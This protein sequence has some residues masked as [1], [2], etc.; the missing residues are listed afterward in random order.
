M[1]VQSTIMS[2]LFCDICKNTGK[3]MGLGSIEKKCES[4]KNMKYI[5]DKF[6][7]IIK[8]ICRNPFKN[9]PVKIAILIFLISFFILWISKSYESLTFSLGAFVAIFAALKY[10]LDQANY[11]KSLFEKRYKIFSIIDEV[12]WDYASNLKITEEMIEKISLNLMRRSYFLFSKES[13]LFIEKFRRALIDIKHLDSLET[14]KNKNFEE[15]VKKSSEFLV[16][17]IDKQN[18]SDN[19]REIKISDY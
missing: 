4:C 7:Y 1:S 9:H 2:Y 18:L 12:M 13:Y 5:R 11:H 17:I 6:F 16:S 14:R 8:E 15:K 19:F 3:I 10:K